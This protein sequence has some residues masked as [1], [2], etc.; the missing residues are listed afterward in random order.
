MADRLDVRSFDSISFTVASPHVSDEVFDDVEEESVVG[1]FEGSVIASCN[2]ARAQAV[3]YVLS[4]II[5]C[6][7]LNEV[8][9]AE[10]ICV[11][12]V[13]RREEI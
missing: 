11:H 5:D 12:C 7:P 1:G 13:S 2:G 10:E 3:E 9:V 6:N 4:A 8:R